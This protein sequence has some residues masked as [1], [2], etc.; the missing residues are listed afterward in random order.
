MCV[1]VKV[2][3]LGQLD[4]CKLPPQAQPQK[5]RAQLANRRISAIPLNRAAA[6]PLKPRA[7]VGRKR[8]ALVLP[9][10]RGR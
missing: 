8:R 5:E 4:N 6:L 9:M 3:S 2:A 1:A 7:L 10:Q